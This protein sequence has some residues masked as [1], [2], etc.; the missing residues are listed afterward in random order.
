[1]TTEIA[2]NPYQDARKLLKELQEK[3]AVFR[4][5]QPLAIG[6]DKQI[7]AQTPDVSRKQL[8]T[9]LGIHTHSLRYLKEMEKA[10]VRH[11]LDGSTAD[12][13]T[14]EHRTHASASLKERLK[15][16]AEQHKAKRK[17]EA[18]QRAADEA[19][20]QRTE[21]LNQLAEKFS[22]KP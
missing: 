14:E 10:T 12:E 8:R 21:K 13:I 15:K 2:P 7:I 11:N 18:A 1:M 4:D 22:R 16:N 9:A 5:C 6:I 19:Q 17:A 3:F 20:R